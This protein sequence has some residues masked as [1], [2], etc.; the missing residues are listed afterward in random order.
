MINKLFFLSVLITIHLS[1]NAQCYSIGE[2]LPNQGF[3]LNSTGNLELDNIVKTEISKL[4]NFYGVN[5]DFFFLL[6]TYQ[7]SAF[8]SPQCTQNCNG[9]IMLGLAMIQDLL[10]K[11]HGVECIKAVLAHEFGHCLQ[12]IQGWSEL[13]KRRELHSDF[14]AGYY[15]GKMYNYSNDQMNTL[16]QE[17]YSIG[18]FYFWDV[19]HHGTGIERQCAF[20]EG[21]YYAKENSAGLGSAN[22]Y[23]IQYVIA[24]NP[25]AVRKY[26]QAL[27]Y[28]EEFSR[29][30]EQD[31][32]TGNIG[33]L[34]FKAKDNAKYK[35]LTI[36]GYG[37][38]VVYLINQPYFAYDSN[39]KP[40]FYPPVKEITISSVS[41]G[42]ILPFQIYKTTTLFGDILQWDSQDP[43]HM[44]VQIG[45]TKSLEFQM[46]GLFKRASV[47]HNF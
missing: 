32:K 4:E 13:G 47:T 20:L 33:V 25:C 34:K 24:D 19:N 3:V 30:Y 28:Q 26:K 1:V 23:G 10:T 6:E 44:P 15:I 11:K 14:M 35:I 40:N 27:S 2:S 21:Y 42:I 12:S 43:E 29:R 5:I 22:S 17:F 38:R 45:T 31:L 7:K 16:F 36:N 39:G 46:G 9:S 37:Q 8:F 18:D 41:K